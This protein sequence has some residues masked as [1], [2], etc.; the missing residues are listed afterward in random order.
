SPSP[1][2]PVGGGTVL[3]NSYLSGS[4]GGSFEYYFYELSDCVGDN[5]CSIGYHLLANGNP[6]T[7]D[8]AAIVQFILKAI[9]FEASDHLNTINGTSMATPYVAGVAAMV[10]AF[11]PDY[12]YTDVVNSIKTGGEDVVALNGITTTGK[13]ANAM[14]SLAHI[15]PPEGVA[16]SVK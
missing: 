12:N 13:A 6:I 3:G 16:A 1:G 8:G 10:R 11:N 2:S 14:G 7:A 4:S 15:N 9:D 5:N